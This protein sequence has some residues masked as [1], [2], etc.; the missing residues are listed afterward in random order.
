MYDKNFMPMTE[1]K[2]T[3]FKA[4]KWDI[5]PRSWSTDLRDKNPTVHKKEIVNTQVHPQ[6]NE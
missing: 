4:R 5:P 6:I 3:S 2:L 1:V